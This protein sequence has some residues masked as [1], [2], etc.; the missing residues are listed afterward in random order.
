MENL[1]DDKK[2]ELSF[3][4]TQATDNILAWKAHILNSIHQDRACV[5]LLDML[6]ETSV[7]L[8]QDWAMK[9][10]PRKYRESRTDWF[11]KCGIPWH[12]SIAFRKGDE[13]IE[14]L[15]FC[16]IFNSCTQV[17]CLR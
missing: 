8:V 7:L 11:G 3:K 14:L 10:L 2:E 9:Y 16:H 12:I 6:D 13:Q 4:V 1:S 15:T 5:E 17:R